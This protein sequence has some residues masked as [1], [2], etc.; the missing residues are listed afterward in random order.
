MLKMF[1]YQ[2]Q[3]VLAGLTWGP[4][5]QDGFLQYT[6]LA[7]NDLALHWDDRTAVVPQEAKYLGVAS[8]LSV[9]AG[10]LSEEDRVGRV[11]CAWANDMASNDP[12]DDLAADNPRAD[13]TAG[14]MTQPMNRPLFFAAVLVN[15]KP[16]LGAERLFDTWAELISHADVECSTGQID[17]LV[18]TAALAHEIHA[19]VP[20]SQ[21]RD[22]ASDPASS[23]AS[24]A[25]TAPVCVEGRIARRMSLGLP[26]FGM[27][28]KGMTTKGLP[29]WKIAAG[30][31]AAV[32]TLTVGSLFLF[33]F[34]HPKPADPLPV[35]AVHASFRDEAAFA[36]NCLAAFAGDWPISPGWQVIS[37]GCATPEMRDLALKGFAPKYPVAYRIYQLRG[38]FDAAIARKAA[39]AVYAA[40]AHT[41]G[42]VA[43]MEIQGNRL[44]SSF[45]I[46]VPRLEAALAEDT[47]EPL[48]PAALLAATQAVFLGLADN[49]VLDG[50]SSGS[51]GSSGMGAS[52]RVTLNS[53]FDEIFDRVGRIDGAEIARLS[54]NGKTVTLEITTRQMVTGPRRTSRARF[55][56]PREI[57]EEKT[58]ARTRAAQRGA[59]M[60]AVA[61]IMSRTPDTQKDEI[62]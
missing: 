23:P 13:D 4:S 38:G 48:T 33:P 21:F 26:A 12:A 49:I 56:P 45:E 58:A 11:L 62:I 34:Q 42:S 47:T 30:S 7:A 57:A 19:T 60:Q 1:T 25:S 28:T 53:G 55:T 44:V 5:K 24:S 35:P 32:L 14:P 61:P 6:P 46:K 3:D 27:I 15:G 51:N 2:D 9:L 59:L 31:A 40:H 39:E 29:A 10:H 54:R 8:L 50:G 41:A 52:V 36:R 16:A 18:T 17:H 20:V 22:P 43:H 37:E